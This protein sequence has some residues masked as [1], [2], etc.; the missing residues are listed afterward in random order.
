MRRNKTGLFA[1]VLVFVLMIIAAGCAG[2]GDVTT[3]AGDVKATRE[4][5]QPENNANEE[6]RGEVMEGKTV[7]EITMESGGVIAVELDADAA[8]DTVANFLKLVDE[9]YYDGLTFHRIIKNFMIQGGCPDGTGMG[10]PKERIK[11]E[12]AANGFDNPI[13]HTKGVISMARSGDPNSAGSQ[14]FITNTDATFLDGDYAAFGHVI[15]GI[16]VVDEISAVTT[17]AGDRPNDPVVIKTIR[18]Q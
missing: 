7:I 9:D 12:F 5:P 14:F 3:S 1:L 17:G 8:P 16:E 2:K 13:S 10:G 11:G 6:K 4:A 15:S 18:R